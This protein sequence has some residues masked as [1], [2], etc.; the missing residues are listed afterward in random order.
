MTAEKQFRSDVYDAT[1]ELAKIAG[2]LSCVK[3]PDFIKTFNI[4]FPQRLQSLV[5]EIYHDIKSLI[6]DLSK[7][8]FDTL[9]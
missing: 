5:E 4:E 7:S 3:D 2:K 6:K 8:Y 1:H 9:L